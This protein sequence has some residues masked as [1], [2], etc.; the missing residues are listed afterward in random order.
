[1]ILAETIASFPGDGALLAW[2][3][4]APSPAPP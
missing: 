4:R 1:M 3:K 2:Q